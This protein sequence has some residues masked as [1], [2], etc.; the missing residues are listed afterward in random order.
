MGKGPELVPPFKNGSAHVSSVDLAERL[1]NL[2]FLARTTTTD[3]ERDAYLL[4]LEEDARELGERLRIK[5]F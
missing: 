3:A 2:A 4:L 5:K 1:V